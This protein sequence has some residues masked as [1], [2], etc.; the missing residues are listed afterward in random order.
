[1][2]FDGKAVLHIVDIA[3][4]FSAAT[5]LDSHGSSFRPS[6]QEIRLAFFMTRYLVYTGY[7]NRLRTDQGFV[8]FSERWKQLSDFN[9]IQL[10]VSELKLTADWA[11]DNDTINR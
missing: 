1:M 10:R 6:V 11:L 7:S 9:G 4:H 2:F 8:F 3:T 5:F